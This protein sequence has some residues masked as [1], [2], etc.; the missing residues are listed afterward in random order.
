MTTRIGFTL[1]FTVT[2]EIDLNAKLLEVNYSFRITAFLKYIKTCPEGL[3]FMTDVHMMKEDNF[4]LLS[5][6]VS[7]VIKFCAI[8]TSML[9]QIENLLY[10]GKSV[11]PAVGD[12]WDPK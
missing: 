9:A 1:S 7:S 3:N 2:Q 4:K 6:Q 10:S 8:H 12:D 11:L 5:D